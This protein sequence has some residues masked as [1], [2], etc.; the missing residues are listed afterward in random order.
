MTA[1]NKMDE[2]RRMALMV[3]P[4]FAHLNNGMMTIRDIR[5]K[6]MSFARNHVWSRHCVLD[7][8]NKFYKLQ[9]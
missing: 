9:L 3:S 8:G 2:E 6:C 5:W 4:S 1:V 7:L